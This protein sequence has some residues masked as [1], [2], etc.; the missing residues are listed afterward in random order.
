MNQHHTLERE[1]TAWFIEVAG[2]R[3]PDYVDDILRQTVASRQRPAWTFPERWLPVSVMTRGRLLL[4][5]IPWRAVGL[6][7]IL[8]ALL[9]AM[10]A[11]Y[12]GSSSRPGGVPF[13]SDRH[14]YSILLPDKSWTAVERPGTWRLGDFFE[15]NT[16]SGVDYFERMDRADGPPLYAYLSSQP[17]P[18]GMELQTWI[19]LNDAANGVAVPCFSVVGTFERRKVDGETARV[20]AQRCDEFDG[21]GAWMTIQTLVAHGGRGYGFYVWPVDRGTAMPSV[22]VLRAE[23]GRLLDQLAFTD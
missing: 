5:P 12:V 1:L 8:A 18:A 4:R 17:I 15:A 7:A 22:D 19:D 2:P 14:T 6:V 11:V 23:A 9:A 3:T 20:A 16:D 10:V 13:T 21:A